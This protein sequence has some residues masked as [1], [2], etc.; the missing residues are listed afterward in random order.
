MVSALI[1]FPS[2]A[3]RC[4][5]RKKIRVTRLTKP[6]RVRE[7]FL[8]ACLSLGITLATLAVLEVFLRVADF[9]ELRDTL[10][11]R[12]LNHAYDPE[13]GWQPV[14]NSSGSITTFRT[15]HYQHNSL[16]LRDQEF[17]LDAKPTIMFLGTPLSG[18]SIPRQT[19]ASASC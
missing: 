13:L 17:G 9:R 2:V 3:I 16:G 10:S 1:K 19:S 5:A 15:T 8:S 14:P 11:E 4:L 6:N 7:L 12:S 18:A